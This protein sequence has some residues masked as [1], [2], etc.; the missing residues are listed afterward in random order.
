[1]DEFAADSQNRC[2]ARAEQRTHD[3]CPTNIAV[4]VYW[5]DPAGQLQSEPGLIRDISRS[6]FGL[7]FGQLLDRGQALSVQTRVGSLQCVVRHTRAYGTKYFVGLE[8]VTASDGR[9]HE[10]SLKNLRQV[11]AKPNT[12]R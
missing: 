12:V 8:V 1:M 11:L 9:D 3:R 7:E 5:L 4:D 2:A 6:G 10:G